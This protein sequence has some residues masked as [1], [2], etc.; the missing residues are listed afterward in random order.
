MCI[1]NN[2]E[3]HWCSSRLQVI[4]TQDKLFKHCIRCGYASFELLQPLA[5]SIHEQVTSIFAANI[6]LYIKSYPNLK[7]GENRKIR[8]NRNTHVGKSLK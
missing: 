6:V 3:R 4:S 1:I 5:T 2:I 8:K 7:F